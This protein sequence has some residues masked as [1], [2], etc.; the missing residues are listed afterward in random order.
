MT[1][2][3]KGANMKNFTI[4]RNGEEI[5]LTY[6]EMSAAY[7]HLVAV[8]G[9]DRLEEYLDLLENKEGHEKPKM[10]A[11]QILKDKTKCFEFEDSMIDIME[12]EINNDTYIDRIEDAIKAAWGR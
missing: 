2:V 11:K 4:I 12:E 6:D 1:I 10:L 7:K 5:V 3:Q 8:K 9:V